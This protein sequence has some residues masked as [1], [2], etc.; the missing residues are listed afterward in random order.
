[1]RAGMAGTDGAARQ[2]RFTGVD[3]SEAALAG[4]GNS[5]DQGT[6]ARSLAGTGQHLR[7]AAARLVASGVG[8]PVRDARVR[9]AEVEQGETVRYGEQGEQRPGFLKKPG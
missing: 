8:T 3:D 1:M 2:E 9:D 4:C 5:A 6:R 7:G